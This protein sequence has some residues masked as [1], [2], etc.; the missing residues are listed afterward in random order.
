MEKLFEVAQGHKL[1]LIIQLAAFYGLRR[2][3]VMGLRWEA[4]DFEAKTLTIRHI[5]TSTRIDGKKIL[6]EADRAKTKSS[7]RTLP[8]VKRTKSLCRCPFWVS[9]EALFCIFSVLQS[10]Y[11]PDYMDKRNRYM[12]DHTDF[13][14]A[15]W[16][17]RP[18]GTGKTVTYARGRNGKLINVIDPVTL[19]VERL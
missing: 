19:A 12:V 13:I 4:I 1:E 7:L 2:A 3:E 17:G 5:V 11:S 9:A 15:V 10:R 6:V 18:S 14:I 8:L 16:D